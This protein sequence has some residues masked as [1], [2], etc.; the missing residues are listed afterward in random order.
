[1]KA[2]RP[3]LVVQRLGA[4][5]PGRNMLAIFQDTLRDESGL[6]LIEY[7]LMCS[8]ITILAWGG[9]IALG[10]SIIAA[11]DMIANAVPVVGG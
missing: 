2:L 4:F 1:M 11:F 8:I 6:T 7:A 9:L 5:G 3:M 10:G